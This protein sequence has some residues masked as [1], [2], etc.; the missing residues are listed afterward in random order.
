[1][2]AV[3]YQEKYGK[4][5]RLPTQLEIKAAEDV[6]NE[7]LK[8]IAD[9]IPYGMSNEPLPDPKTLGFSIPLYGFKKMVRDFHKSAIV[10][11]DDVCEMDAI[12]TNQ[13]EGV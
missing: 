9:K 11:I 3:V 4:E 10:S 7:I 13:N 2:T 8:E 6:P 12:S 1:M 5:Y